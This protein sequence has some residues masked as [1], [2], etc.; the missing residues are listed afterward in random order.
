MWGNWTHKWS[1]C[2]VSVGACSEISLNIRKK[3]FVKWEQILLFLIPWIPGLCT[4]KE[5]FRIKI[6]VCENEWQK[7]KETTNIVNPGNNKKA[8]KSKPAFA[9]CNHSIIQNLD[10]W[11]WNRC[12]QETNDT[13]F[14][15]NTKKVIN[16][17]TIPQSL[18]TQQQ[19]ST[20]ESN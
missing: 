3:F 9:K 8:I 18:T 12:K 17:G 20:A 16:R 2:L 15:F 5:H 19:H 1:K 11:E 4:L 7:Y 10:N 6:D 13:T 14:N